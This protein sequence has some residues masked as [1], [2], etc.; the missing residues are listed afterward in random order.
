MVG[1]DSVSRMTWMRSLPKTYDY[2]VTVLG[3]VVLEGYN[4]VGDG[5]PAALLPILTGKPEQELPEARRGHK[6]NTVDGHPWIWK[7][8]KRLGYVTQYAEDRANH[9]D[10]QLPNARLQRSTG[11]SLHADLFSRDGE[12]RTETAQKRGASMYRLFSALT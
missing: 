10:L 11:R 2:L 7:D 4:I 12:T 8:L 6:G 5:T 3:A 1:F 9:G